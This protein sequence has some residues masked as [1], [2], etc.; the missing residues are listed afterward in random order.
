MIRLSVIAACI[1]LLA[2]ANGCAKPRAVGATAPV[3]APARAITTPKEATDYSLGVSLAR[4]LKAQGAGDYDAA[5]L[6]RGL[7]DEL[8]GRK[9]AI[10]EDDLR[11]AV[12]AYQNTV[13][14]RSAQTFAKAAEDNQRNG[15]TF[16]AENKARPGVV[17]RPSGLQYKILKAGDGP[18]PADG[19]TVEVN[20]RGTLLDGMEFDS[21]YRNG[22]P[23]TFKVAALIAGWKEALPLMPVGSKWQLVVPAELAYGPRG[24]GPIIGPNATLVFE[25]ELL[26]IK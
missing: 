10:S 7:Q 22:R 20:Y 13:R 6:V 15:E 23:A 16:L 21:S 12:L 4:S 11:A 18:K 3:V 1:G 19:D 25:M 2:L 5:L 9:L 8:A 24:M 14:K 17:T 26:A